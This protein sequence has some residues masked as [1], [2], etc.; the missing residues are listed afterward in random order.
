MRHTNY[1][2]IAAAYDRRYIE[3]DYLGIARALI[4]FVGDKS[5]KVLEVGCGTGHW[6]QQL[7]NRNINAIGIDLSRSML[8]RAREKLR[9]ASAIHARAENLPFADSTFDRIFC[10]NAHHH[11]ADKLRFFEGARRVRGATSARQRRGR[12]GPTQWNGHAW[13]YLPACRPHKRRVR[14]RPQAHHCRNPEQR[15]IAIDRRP[16]RLRNLWVGRRVGMKP[17]T[18]KPRLLRNNAI[19]RCTCS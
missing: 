10:I 12:R 2:E 13:S 18:T 19:G 3:E 14:C 7:Q 6:L 15:P 4:A 1:D 11:F 17:V 5:P 16:A 8:L 9:S